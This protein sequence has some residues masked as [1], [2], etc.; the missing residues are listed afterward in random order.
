MSRVNNS[1]IDNFYDKKYFQIHNAS[2]TWRVVGEGIHQIF[3]FV[4][5]WGRRNLNF[6][7]GCS[8]R[9]LWWC[10]VGEITFVYPW[11][12]KNVVLHTMEKFHFSYP[13]LHKFVVPCTME[14]FVFSYPALHKIVVPCAM[15]KYVIPYSITICNYRTALSQIGFLH[16]LHYHKLVFSIVHRRRKPVRDSA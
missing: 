3:E 14:K 6:S 4:I 2:F 16:T 12:H 9:N 5:L 10:I 8:T 7:I 11:V 13:S 1:K 15:E